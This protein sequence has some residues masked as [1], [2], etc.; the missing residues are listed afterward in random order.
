MKHAPTYTKIVHMI[1]LKIR[2]IHATIIL[3]FKLAHDFNTYKITQYFKSQY[4]SRNCMCLLFSD[5]YIY[6]LKEVS[7]SET[8]KRC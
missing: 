3:M 2:Q 8:I 7:A 6:I 5:I 4:A 1:M